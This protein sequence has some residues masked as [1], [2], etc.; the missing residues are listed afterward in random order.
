MPSPFAEVLASLAEAFEALDAD[1]YVFG[2]QAALIHGAARMTADVDVT[3]LAGDRS[4]EELVQ[5][6]ERA[7]FEMRGADAEFVRETRVIPVVH[8]ATGIN[9]DVVLGGPGIEETFCS[10]SRP[11][12]L[13]GTTVPVASAEDVVA[14]KILSGRPK[15]RED[16]VAMIAA[17]GPALN[18]D[19]VRETLELLEKALD[20]SD[21]IPELERARAEAER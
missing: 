21:L 6:I 19:R 13:G 17:Q 20:R 14:M 9:A 12:D 10:R 5:S 7:G 1:W 16:V 18:D 4:P 15:D 11:A 2:A 8:L 3:V